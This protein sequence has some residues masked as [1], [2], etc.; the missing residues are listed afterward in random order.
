M[1]IKEFVSNTLSQIVKSI[2]DVDGVGR[3]GFYLANGGVTFDL[4]VTVTSENKINGKASGSLGIRMANAGGSVEQSNTQQ[5]Q[6][7]SRVQFTIEQVW[8]SI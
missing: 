3:N 4:A 6:A 5:N 1:D 7:V 8:G 2:T